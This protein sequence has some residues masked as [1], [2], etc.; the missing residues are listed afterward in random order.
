MQISTTFFNITLL[1]NEMHILILAQEMICG[2]TNKLL[3]RNINENTQPKTKSPLIILG[4]FFCKGNKQL[5]E[6]FNFD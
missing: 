3:L 2:N 5:I 4:W 1:S 6:A